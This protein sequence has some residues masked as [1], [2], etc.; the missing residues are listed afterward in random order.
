MHLHLFR[1]VLLTSSRVMLPDSEYFREF[2]IVRDMNSKMSTFSLTIF[3]TSGEKI[4]TTS[5]F[6]NVTPKPNQLVT[7]YRPFSPFKGMKPSKFVKCWL[8]ILSL[9]PITLGKIGRRNLRC[10]IVAKVKRLQ[11]ISFWHVDYTKTS[12][13][14]TL[15]HWI[16]L[17]LKIAIALSTTS[18]IQRS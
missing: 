3:G 4:M 16:S 1:T 5:H 14:K 7:L 18:H 17:T 2:I 11:N 10:V 6:W 12:D 15:T 8:A 9:Q 13:L